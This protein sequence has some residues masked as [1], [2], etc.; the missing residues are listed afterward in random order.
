MNVVELGKRKKRLQRAARWTRVV[1]A[2]IGAGLAIMAGWLALTRAGAGVARLSYD[3]PFLV[4][5]AGTAD[6]IR[7]VFADRKAGDRLDR[8]IQADL[9]DRL[10]EAGARAVI[11]DVIFLGPHE[12]D[13]KFAAA[14]RRFRGV[15]PDNKPLDPT[16]PRRR[17]FLAAGVKKAGATLAEDEAATGASEDPPCDTLRRAADGSGRIDMAHSNLTV[18]QITAV[19]SVPTDEGAV[20]GTLGRPRLMWNAA[21]ALGADLQGELPQHPPRW[22]NYADPP[23]TSGKLADSR[24]IPSCDASEILNGVS[25]ISFKDKIVLIG[26]KPGVLG[27]LPGQDLFLTP[28]HTFAPGELPMMSGVEIHANV[29]SNLLHREWLTRSSSVPCRDC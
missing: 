23:A 22:I 13:E 27:D 1:V 3:V 19:T 29:L 8:G 9:L 20:P 24:A 15:G 25:R 10:N 11:Y 7:I 14:I 16:S 2:V 4:H 17:V 26:C 12:A 28:F 18:R 21:V 5:R 6:D